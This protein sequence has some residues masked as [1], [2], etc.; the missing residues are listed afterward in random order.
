MRGDLNRENREVLL[1]SISPMREAPV[2]RLENVSDGKPNMNANRKSDDF[3]VLTTR[4]N[5]AGT[6]VADR[7]EERR[8]LKGSVVSIEDAPDTE[9]DPVSSA[10]RQPRQGSSV[11]CDRLT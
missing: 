3:V 9:P 10:M 8:S 11:C 7:V 2:E 6:P 1:V 4:G 5:K